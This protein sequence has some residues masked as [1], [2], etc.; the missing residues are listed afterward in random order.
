M[1]Y[2]ILEKGRSLAEWKE[3]L[4]LEL[5][6]CHPGDKTKRIGRSKKDGKWYGFSH[7][8][9]EGFK[10]KKAAIKFADSVR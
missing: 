1:N 4:K 6:F 9:I 3:H 5:E 2:V 10:D 7:R 8:A